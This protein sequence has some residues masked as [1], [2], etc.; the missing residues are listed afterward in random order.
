VSRAA[1][2]TTTK[3]RYNAA[4]VLAGLLAF[5]G[6]VPLAT[7]GFGSGSHGNPW[8]A[9]P[10]LLIFLIPIAAM[11]WGWRAGTDANVEGVR[12]R[13]LGLGS[14][15][16]AWTEIVGIV[17]QGRKVFAALGDD[18]AVPLP[19]VTRAD[20]PRLVAASGQKINTD[21]APLTPEPADQ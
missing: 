13:P 8:Y 4:I 18:R 19:A 16:I 6:A 7:S 1:R 20:I 2:S 9:Y 21:D 17:P 5:L 3:F 11:V 15:P 10:L 12:T 14:R